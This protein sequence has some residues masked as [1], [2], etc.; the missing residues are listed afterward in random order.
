MRLIGAVIVRLLVAGVI[1]GFVSASEVP[2]P[3]RIGVSGASLLFLVLY[4]LNGAL[5]SRVIARP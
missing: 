3:V 4:L 5:S 2:V 1:E